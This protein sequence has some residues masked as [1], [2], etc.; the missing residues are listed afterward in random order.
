MICNAY[1]YTYHMLFGWVLIGPV[2]QSSV[3]NALCL[4]AI[5]G[6]SLETLMDRFWCIEEPEGAD[7]SFTTDGRC[8][9]IFSAKRFINNA[10]RYSVPLLLRK[11]HPNRSFENTR[12]MALK[13][14]EQIE[15]KL[16]RDEVL[17]VAYRQFMTECES[18]GYM[19]VTEKTGKYIIPHH[20]VCKVT[21]DDEIKLHVVFDASARCRKSLG[22]NDV[23]DEG[24]KLQRDLVDV[25]LEFRIFRYAFSTDI[26]KMYRQILINDE[27]RPYQYVLWRATPSDAI[28][29]LV[30]GV[31]I[32][33]K[34]GATLAFF[35]FERRYP[36]RRT[37]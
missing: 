4:S 2:D 11:D 10:G 29:E 18:L 26:C 27:Y 33:S 35:G 16:L 17:G 3:C 15:Q 9:S 22:L 30:K 21:V 31:S 36:C 32:S 1:H 20:A 28:R 12:Q 19:T 25:L 24:P 34:S 23:L 14:F 5:V 7:Q 6:P 8:E 37:S 13:R